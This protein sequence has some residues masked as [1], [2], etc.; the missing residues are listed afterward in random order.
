MKGI[1]KKHIQF[2]AVHTINRWRPAI[3][4]TVPN[5]MGDKRGARAL[6][7][8]LNG[9]I[10]YRTEGDPLYVVIWDDRT[11][12]STAFIVKEDLTQDSGI[13]R[14]PIPYDD[15]LRF[16]KGERPSNDVFEEYFVRARQ[17]YCTDVKV[18]VL[19]ED[20]PP[21]SRSKDLTAYPARIPRPTT[22][23]ELREQLQIRIDESLQLSGEARYQELSSADP[24]PVRIDIQ[25]TAFLRNPHVIVEVLLRANGVCEECG[26]RAP[27][28]RASDGTPYLEVHHVRHLSQGGHDTVENAKALCPNCHRAKHYA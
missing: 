17:P 8:R 23:K 6:F 27:F 10:N 4:E 18:E 28:I 26:N 15:I 16:D 3:H 24:L 14:A 25:T 21:T 2:R 20:P 9:A 19:P 7:G 1:K 22:D 5:A 13:Q 12:E 11:P